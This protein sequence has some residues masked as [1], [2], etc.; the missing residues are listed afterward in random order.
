MRNEDKSIL[1]LDKHARLYNQLSEAFKNEQFNI[2]LFSTVSGI[3]T[4]SNLLE[5]QEY[6]VVLVEEEFEDGIRGLDIVRFIRNKYPDTE[7]ML[8][9]SGVSEIEVTD[10][11]RYFKK[12]I[13]PNV[14][15]INIKLSIRK[16]HIAKRKNRALLALH[17]ASKN[18]LNSQSEDDI[19]RMI[20]D[21]ASNIMD[22]SRSPSHF[23][24]LALLKSN[25]N[26]LE[27]HQAHHSREVWILLQNKLSSNII[28]LT[29]PNNSRI[30]IVGRVI[31]KRISQRQGD[32][33][34]DSDYIDLHSEVNS[35][36]AV[37]IKMGDQIFGVIN[38]EHPDRNAFDE[39]D[40]IAMEALAALVGVAIEKVRPY[41]KEKK[42]TKAL[43][44]LHNMGALINGSISLT[45]DQIIKEAVKQAKNL[46]LKKGD[47]YLSHFAIKENNTLRFYP[48]HNLEY[49][50]QLIKKIHL[51]I[52]LDNPPDGRIGIIGRAVK[53]SKSQLVGNV[54]SDQDYITFNSSVRS[55]LA[56]PI[57]VNNQ[58]FGAINIEHPKFDA[59]SENDKEN[60]EILAIKLAV[61]LKNSDLYR[62]ENKRAKKFEAL[63]ETAGQ[64]IANNLEKTLE[65]I[66]KQA[67]I[68]VG[69]PTGTVMSFSHISLEKD[70]MLKIMSASPPSI[71]NLY[72][73]RIKYDIDIRDTNSKYGISGLCFRVAKTLNI[74]NVKENRD[75]IEV[76]RDI[77]SQLSVPLVYNA[78]PIG[79]I[80]IESHKLDAFSKIDEEVVGLLAK[81]AVIAIKNAQLFAEIKN[82]EDVSANLAKKLLSNPSEQKRITELITKSFNLDELGNLL[83]NLGLTIDQVKGDTL[84]SKAIEIVQMM[85]RYGR[86]GDLIEILRELRPRRDW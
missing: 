56:V 3:T 8:L 75:Y 74:R 19:L 24:H 25:E 38:V 14:L 47:G 21:L 80:S 77:K 43:K 35:Q 22:T 78:I 71:L 28:N 81:M 66:A 70:G 46:M 37:P 12:P 76:S 34:N 57:I 65:T 16:N 23:S 17:D 55:Q 69:I 58:V 67:L 33:K 45:R 15:A 1:L 86:E 64:L 50:I 61:A 27:F 53:R 59:F 7:V 13:D 18:I 31:R 60:L 10:T 20:V 85:I 48:E 83:F 63:Y 72:K 52:D 36:L 26:V 32:V 62:Q 39:N 40:Q 29:N 2:L 30:G 41:E 79:V 54:E 44:V 84:E 51:T 42:Q 5:S 9:A 68:V 4:I 49:E 73:D 6:A 82:Q 11:F